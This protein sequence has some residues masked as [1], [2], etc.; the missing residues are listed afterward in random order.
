MSEAPK[1]AK[2]LEALIRRHDAEWP[3]DLRD[4]AHR[5]LLT[6]KSLGPSAAQSPGLVEAAKKELAAFAAAY[7][8][9][10]KR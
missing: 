9:W 2:D 8:E 6:L 3:K 1:T 10:S 7:E 5:A 4:A